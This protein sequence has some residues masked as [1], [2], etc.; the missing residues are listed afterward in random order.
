MTAPWLSCAA[1][2]AAWATTC[3]TSA[4]VMWSLIACEDDGK[5]SHAAHSRWVSGRSLR[6]STGDCL[7]NHYKTARRNRPLFGISRPR[8][9]LGCFHEVR[10]AV[11]DGPVELTGGASGGRRGVPVLPI[12]N[13]TKTSL[14]S[15]HAMSPFTL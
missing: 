12:K 10:G 6:N 3:R 2:V 1:R 7:A 13:E 15:V 4:S 14:G 8:V 11:A 9:R 5:S